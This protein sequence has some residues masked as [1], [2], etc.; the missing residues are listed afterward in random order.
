MGKKEKTFCCLCSKYKEEELEFVTVGF[1]EEANL[2]V[3]IPICKGCTLIIHNL[4]RI[5][6]G[7]KM[8]AIK[9]R[10]ALAGREVTNVKDSQG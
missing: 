9:N 2:P 8:K 4:K 10:S 6:A 1:V 5:Y 7:V 3:T